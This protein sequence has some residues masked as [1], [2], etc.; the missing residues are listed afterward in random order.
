LK[1]T[2]GGLP[3]SYLIFHP[4]RICGNGGWRPSTNRRYYAK[5]REREKIPKGHWPLLSF[6]LVV[7]LAG[8]TLA[9]HVLGMFDVD[10]FFLGHFA[11]FQGLVFQLLNTLLAFF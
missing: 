11:V 5:I 1:G 8:D 3:Y 2:L 6:L 10:L 4:V 7:P 9:L